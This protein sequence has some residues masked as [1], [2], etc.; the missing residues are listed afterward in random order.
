MVVLVIIIHPLVHPG[1]GLV[2][3]Y[4]KRQPESWISKLRWVWYSLAIGAPLLLCAMSIM[5][6]VYTS[7]K[8]ASLLVDTAWLALGLVII[9]M[10]V[11]I[12]VVNTMV[13]NRDGV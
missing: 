6:N 1:T 9:N 13:R 12:S 10:V 4:Y 2:A 7:T 3:G 8:L 5:G 11:L